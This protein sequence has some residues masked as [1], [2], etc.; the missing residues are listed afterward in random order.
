[1]IQTVPHLGMIIHKMSN[2]I[3][4]YSSDSRT[5]RFKILTYFLSHRYFGLSGFFVSSGALRVCATS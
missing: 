4:K 3:P 1:M 2:A 5:L